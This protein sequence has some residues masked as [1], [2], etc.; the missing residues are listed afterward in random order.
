MGQS[1]L[2]FLHGRQRSLR[3]DRELEVRSFSS[4]R[5]RTYW[6]QKGRYAQGWRYAL[7]LWMESTRWVQSRAR[8]RGNAGGREKTLLRATG[9]NR[10]RQCGCQIGETST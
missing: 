4:K 6:V 7:G 1:P 10:R 3:K 8:Q 9:R 5:S 2:S